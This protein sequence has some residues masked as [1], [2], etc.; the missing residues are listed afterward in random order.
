MS[1]VEEL[2]DE[3][4][5][6]IGQLLLRI[7]RRENRGRPPIDEPGERSAARESLRLSVYVL[8]CAAR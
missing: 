4:W 3:Q 7:E 2:M 6:L 1:G 8:T 5:K